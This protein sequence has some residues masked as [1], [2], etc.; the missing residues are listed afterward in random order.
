MAQNCDLIPRR[1]RSGQHGTH[2][3]CRAKSCWAVCACQAP[4]SVVPC[5]HF[6]LVP[7][8]SCRDLPSSPG[9]AKAHSRL[10]CS[11]RETFSQ[12]RDFCTWLVLKE[13]KMVMGRRK[14]AG[15]KDREKS[16]L[17]PKEPFQKPA[18]LGE[19]Y[20]PTNDHLATNLEDPGQV[21]K[22]WHWKLHLIFRFSFFSFFAASWNTLRT[23][24]YWYWCCNSFTSS[25]HELSQLHAQP[26]TGFTLESLSIP[27]QNSRE[28]SCPF[29]RRLGQSFLQ[30]PR[31]TPKSGS[32][33]Y[34]QIWFRFG[35]FKV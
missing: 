16:E 22:L 30:R 34:F 17:S 8:P 18:I 3:L 27:Q 1:G 33:W 15:W 4:L 9:H 23:P 10:V 25:A 5:M 24:A 12:C 20:S 26:A 32:L 29:C 31:D 2:N 14:A 6:L 13:N 19:I 21:N 35:Y 28:L 11:W 7:F